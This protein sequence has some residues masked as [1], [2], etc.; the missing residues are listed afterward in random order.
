MCGSRRLRE[1][2]QTVGAADLEYRRFG[3]GSDPPTHQGAV[4]D[5]AATFPLHLLGVVASV[6]TTAGRHDVCNKNVALCKGAEYLAKSGKRFPG[7]C[8]TETPARSHQY[9]SHACPPA[10]GSPERVSLHRP[11]EISC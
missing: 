5:S 1:R 7:A 10:C 9:G 4:H 8:T 3:R 11:S 2:Y 6:Q